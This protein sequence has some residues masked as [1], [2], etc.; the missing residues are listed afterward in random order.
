MSTFSVDVDTA[1]WSNV[2]RILNEGRL[3][4]ADAVRI[5]EMINY[6]R[7]DYRKPA[8]GRPFSVN[9]EVGA[10]P[11][12]PEHRLVRIGLR[13]KDFAAGEHKGSNLVFLIDVSGSME[14]SNKLPLLKKSLKMLVEKLGPRD[15]V[16]I[17]VY[18]GSSGVVLPSTPVSNRQAILDAFDGM[19]AGGSTNGGAG[20]QAAYDL[21][22]KSFIKGG[23]NRVIIATDGDFNV[24]TA[25]RGSLVRMIK[26]KAG[27]GV[28]LS[29]LGFGMGNYKDGTLEKLAQHGNGNYAY[30]DS[31]MEARKV[32]VQEVGGTLVT[33]AKDVKLQVEFNPEQVTAYRLIGYENRILAHQD[34]NDDK[35]DAGEIGAGH[36]VT[37]LYEVVPAGVDFKVPGIDPLKYQA[38][39]ATRTGSSE[40][41]TVKLRYKN[42]GEK[43]SNLLEYALEGTGASAAPST[44][45]RFASAVAAFGM[46]LRDSSH[47]GAADLDRVLEWARQ[48]RGEDAFGYR[49]GFIAMVQKAITLQAGKE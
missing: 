30:I 43:R 20:I 42:P 11:W 5:E 22:A 32:L 37:A 6:F 33:I 18:A 39:L 8:A 15:R 25:D 12:R 47:K 1:S 41:A 9:V 49:E 17:V 19:R 14:A 4:P 24:G 26:E 40:L 16:G 38:P 2:R 29:V 27:T 48:G 7:Y 13:G 3:P 34:F 35:K 45:F 10:A 36:T 31:P 28:E 21:A 46:I 23:V 44:D